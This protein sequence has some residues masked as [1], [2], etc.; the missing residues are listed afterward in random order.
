MTIAAFLEKTTE[1]GNVTQQVRSLLDQVSA[2]P[3]LLGIGL[4]VR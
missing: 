1:A 3:V 4:L 2:S